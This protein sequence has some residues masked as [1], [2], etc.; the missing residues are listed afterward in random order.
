M[1]KDNKPL[2]REIDDAARAVAYSPSSALDGPI[3][4]YIAAYVARSNAAYE[5]FPDVQCLSYGDGAANTV[6]IVVPV[7]TSPVPLHVYI[8]GG[9]WQELSKRESFFPAVDTMAQG[10]AF[11][12][13]D[14]TLAPHASLDDMVDECCAAIS[15][16]ISK[17]ARLNI[18]P[19]RIVLTGSSAGAHLAAMA[20]LKLPFDMQPA[21]VVLMS[22]VYT[23][24]PLIGTYINDAVGM[25]IATAHRNS[26][27][28]CNLAGFPKTIIAWG[29][30]ETDEFKRQSRHFAQL[31]RTVGGTAETLEIAHRN[32]FDIVE[33]IANDTELG[34][35][36]ASLVSL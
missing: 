32:H 23:L 34:R 21:G 22:G 27:A 36:M 13:V 12:A 15:W 18:D 5:A 10:M 9:Y 11:A 14:Y 16:L 6:D 30:H 25:D 24:E 4:P 26:P 8:H 33:D 2:W 29:E 31:I 1:D 20:C 7:S 35:Q 19:N 28:L 17:A 3:D